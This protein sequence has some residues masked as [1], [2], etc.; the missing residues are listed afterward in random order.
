[1]KK[2]K[3]EIKMIKQQVR[4]ILEQHPKARESANICIT[5][6]MK[7]QNIKSVSPQIWGLADS[8][9]R[10]WRYW[11]NTEKIFITNNEEERYLRS[12]FFKQEYGKK[13]KQ[14]V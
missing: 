5:L 10:A 8:V 13:I 7:S 6:Y 12:T 1:M 11:I 2:S 4:K 9:R 14:E 3:R